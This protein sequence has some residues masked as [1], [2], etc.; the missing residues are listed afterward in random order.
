MANKAKFSIEE[1]KF[2]VSEFQKGKSRLQVKSAFRNEFGDPFRVSKIDSMCFQNVYNTFRRNGFKG[3]GVEEKGSKANHKHNSETSAKVKES[4]GQQSP[5]PSIR[6]VSRATNIPRSTV[7]WHMKEKLDMKFFKVGNSLIFCK[8]PHMALLFFSTPIT[9]L[10]WQCLA[11]NSLKSQLPRNQKN[12]PPN[13]RM[14]RIFMD[15]IFKSKIS[16]VA[17]ILYLSFS[18]SIEF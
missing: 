15:L 5:S 9:F 1:K 13:N 8:I 12:I 2:I 16:Q 14:A 3:I 6:E 7:H 18:V 4:F 10:P 11:L 17:A